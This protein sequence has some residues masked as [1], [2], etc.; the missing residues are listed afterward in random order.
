MYV[1][2]ADIRP[3]SALQ[4]ELPDRSML[5]GGAALVA[6]AHIFAPGLLYGLLSVF[7]LVAVDPPDHQPIAREL[8][9]VEARFVRLG[10][11]RKPG[12]LPNRVVPIKATAPATG[13]AVSKKANPDRP[14]KRPDKGKKPPPNAAEDLLTRLGDRAQAFAEIAEEREREGD[15]EG[16]EWGTA[17]EGREGDIYLGKLVAFFQRGWTLPTTLSRDEVRKLVTKI[18]VQITPS[19]QV[20]AFEIVGPSGN[21]LFDQSVNERLMQLRA[22]K[23]KVPE[24]PIEAAGDF[25]GQTIMVR[26]LGRNAK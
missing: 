21:P 19:G 7:G 2:A 14:A 23:A 17:D 3:P 1:D 6:V 18:S 26:F 4:V 10:V 12:R 5:L 11:K 8:H 24:P 9:V 20:G 13:V 16:V 22:S 15:P 25:L